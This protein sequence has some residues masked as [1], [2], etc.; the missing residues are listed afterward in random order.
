MAQMIGPKS[1]LKA[2]LGHPPCPS[3][4]CVVYENVERQPHLAERLGCLAHR[5]Q[6]GKV[7]L[8]KVHSVVAAVATN[9]TYDRHSAL[10]GTAR[11]H[12]NAALARQLGCRRQ[13]DAGAGTSDQ[14]YATFKLAHLGALYPIPVRAGAKCTATH[15]SPWREWPLASW[16]LPAPYRMVSLGP[17]VPKPAMPLRARLVALRS[18]GRRRKPLF[19]QDFKVVDM[20]CDE[21]A[22][23]LLANAKGIL[24][25]ALWATK[26]EGDRIASKIGPRSWPSALAKN[27]QIH[28]GPVRLHRDSVV[29]SFSWRALAGPSL[30]P[31]LDADLEVAPFGPGQASLTM[32]GTYR[33]PG[34][35]LG[36]VADELLLHRVANATVRDFLEA[37][38]Q[39]LSSYR[40]EFTKIVP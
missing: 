6:P 17:K 32:R 36:K 10:F 12:N 34:G 33:P 24:T 28:L 23:H 9:S 21:A 1:H 20:A 16:G 35:I 4:A 25:R 40:D 14:K 31:R 11:K 27:V 18:W 26:A 37:V 39:S 19:V 13:A 7:Q 22:G 15:N 30:F 5:S 38:C 29:V 8:D 3:H 2:F